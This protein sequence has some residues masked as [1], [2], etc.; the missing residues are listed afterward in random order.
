MK[1]TTFKVKNFYHLN[2]FVLDKD[3]I[4]IFQS[5]NSTICIID[6]FNKVITFWND[7]NYSKTTTKHLKLFLNEYLSNVFEKSKDIEKIIKDW[8]FNTPYSEYKVVLNYDL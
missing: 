8:F 3:W 4:S 7:Y 2:Q 1:T 6:Y 5:Y